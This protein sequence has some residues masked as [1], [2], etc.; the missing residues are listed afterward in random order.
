MEKNLHKIIL[1]SRKELEI[2]GV[3]EVV[4]YDDDEVEIDTVDGRISINGCGFKITKLNTD[5]GI[6]SLFGTVDSIYYDDS[7]PDKQSIFKRLFK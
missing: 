7:A 5:E 2:S 6:L 4:A 3:N 1:I